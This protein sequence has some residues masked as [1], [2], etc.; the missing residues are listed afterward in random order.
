MLDEYIDELSVPNATVLEFEDNGYTGTNLN[1]PAVQ[2]ML[3]MVRCG[4]VNCVIVKDFSRFSRDSLESGY[5][6][7]QV[8][9][10]YGVR[11][12][13]LSDHYDSADYIGDTG[14][15]DVAFKFMMHEYY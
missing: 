9:P 8:F 11:F 3:E 4:K 1:R 12:I 6:I 7:E 5:Y 13:S 10:L 15:L 2:E 14:G